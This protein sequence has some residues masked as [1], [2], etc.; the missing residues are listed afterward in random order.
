MVNRNIFIEIWPLL[1][2]GLVF[3]TAV[4]LLFVRYFQNRQIKLKDSE[5]VQI[6]ERTSSSLGMQRRNSV[7]SVKSTVSNDNQSQK[8]RLIEMMRNAKD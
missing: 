5:A 3:L 2:A 1:I 4:L 7:L 8:S 6:P